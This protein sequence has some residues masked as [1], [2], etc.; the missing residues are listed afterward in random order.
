MEVYVSDDATFEESEK[1]DESYIDFKSISPK[2]EFHDLI[3]DLKYYLGKCKNT[4]KGEYVFET[5]VPS[6]HVFVVGDNRYNSNDSRL[7]VGFVDNRCILGKVAFRL[8][9]FG[10]VQ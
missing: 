5:Q 6:G 4:A 7:D 3:S 8:S 1:L 9:P 10:K 2:N